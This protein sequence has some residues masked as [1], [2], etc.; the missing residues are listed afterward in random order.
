M[1]R[2]PPRST[3]FPYTTLFR[4]QCG[5]SRGLLHQQGAGTADRREE[6]RKRHAAEKARKKQ[7][8]QQKRRNVKL[9]RE[10]GAAVDRIFPERQT[11][12][13]L[14]KLANRLAQIHRADTE[15]LEHTLAQMRPGAERLD[16]HV[17]SPRLFP[18]SP[19]SPIKWWRVPKL[20]I[21]E[22]PRKWGDVIWKK[23]LPIGELR[24]QKSRLCPRAPKWSPLH[25]I[26]IPALHF[27]FKR[28]KFKLWRKE[29]S[30][31]PVAIETK[32]K[33]QDQNCTKNKANQKDQKD[34][35]QTH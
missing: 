12:A 26:E 30:E 18:N 28:S 19:V 22:K 32:A 7:E 31:L 35:S 8:R 10:F 3:L 20:A 6:D 21:G 13:R 4:S 9:V 5:G 34:Q 33:Q 2:R 25:G 1:I 17:E 11:R 24:L 27:S 29:N 23:N 15:T 16:I 14:T